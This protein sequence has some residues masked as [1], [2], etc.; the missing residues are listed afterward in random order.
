LPDQFSSNL[1]YILLATGAGILGSVLALIW[2]PKAK[3][4]SAVPHF[5]AGAVLTAVA[6]NVAEE[7]LVENIQAEESIFSTV[8]LFSGFLV[9]LAL[10]MLG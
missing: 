1:L 9:L 4:R 8:M 5:A 7:L 10:K 2:S 3:I 6:S